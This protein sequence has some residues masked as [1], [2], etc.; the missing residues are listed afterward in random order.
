MDKRMVGAV[1]NVSRIAWS[2]EMGR[3]VKAKVGY[4]SRVKYLLN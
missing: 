1:A 4:D 2:L 3:K